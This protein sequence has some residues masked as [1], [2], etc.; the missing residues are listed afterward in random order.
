MDS[1]HIERDVKFLLTKY[2][3]CCT[4]L[5]ATVQG[6]A[7]ARQFY[8]LLRRYGEPTRHYHTPSHVMRVVMEFERVKSEFDRPY[9][10]LAALFYA[11]SVSNV[12]PEKSADYWKFVAENAIG[13]EN[14]MAVIAVRDMIALSGPHP[15]AD[16]PHDRDTALFLDIELAIIGSE[17]SAYDESGSAFRKE[18]REHY[19]DDQWAMVRIECFLDPLLQSKTIFFTPEFEAH[20][21]ERARANLME[22]RIQLQ[23]II[24]R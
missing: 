11:Q 4:R 17:P 23:R 8:G 18:C 21:G 14:K 7:L 9:R 20:Y 2:M 6:Q 13:I 12:Q 10:V 15:S 3:D 5:G 16:R 19:T 22:E 24:S 1:L